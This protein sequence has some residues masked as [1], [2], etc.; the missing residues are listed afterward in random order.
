MHVDFGARLTLNIIREWYRNVAEEFGLVIR[1]KNPI[2]T[3]II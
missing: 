2:I 3:L 1:I